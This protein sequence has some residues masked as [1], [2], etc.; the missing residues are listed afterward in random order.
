[1]RSSELPDD[2]D[3]EPCENAAVTPSLIGRD[4]QLG[5]LEGVIERG[6]HVGA[7]A[8]VVGPAGIGKTTLVRAA[9]TSSGCR[10][11][12]GTCL[13]GGGA[14]GY[15][16]WTQAL[17]GVA[18]AFGVGLARELAGDDRRLL[19]NIVTVAA[20]ADEPVSEGTSALLLWDAVCTWLHALAIQAPLLIVLDDLHWADDSS[21]ALLDFIASNGVTAGVGII[22]LYRP[23]ELTPRS[24]DRLNSVISHADHLELGGLDAAA[25]HVLIERVRGAP[26]AAEVTAEIHRRSAGHP[27]F[28]RELALL[29][30]ADVVG[31]TL[32]PAA[33]REAI[34]R[35]LRPLSRPTRNVL[36]GASLIG[37]RLSSDVVARA[38]EVDDDEVDAAI[39]E[40]IEAGVIVTADDGVPTFGHDL[41]RETLLAGIAA[42]RRA[43]MHRAV[44]GA[45]EDRHDR[46]IAT[47]PAEIAR[48]F[49]L[50]V[51]ADG[52]ERAI[53]WTLAAAAADSRALAFTDA[54]ALLR[55]L[56]TAVVAAG[57]TVSDD[58][59]IDILL[60]EA[61][62]LTRSGSPLDARG[63]LRV[64][65][66]LAQ[67]SADRSRLGRVALAST[68]LG[69]QFSARRDEL[70][71]DLEAALEHLGGANL[72]LEARLTATLAR[73]LQHS[74]AADR[75][76]AEPL[77]VRALHL[78][79]QGSDSDALMVCLLARHDVL[80]T[81]GTAD[82][83]AAIAEEI[84]V[85]ARRSRDAE[86]LAEGLLLLANAE[87]ERGSAAHL[88]ALDECFSIL[89]QLAQPRHRYT[90]ETRRAALAMLHGDLDDAERRIDTST[91]LGTRIREPDTGNVRMSQRLELVRA[92]GVAHEL[93]QFADEAMQHWTGAPVHANAVAAGFHARAGDI[94]RARLNAEAV[95]SLGTWQADRSYLWSVFIRELSWAA[96]ALADHQLCARLLADVAPLAH[97]CG[98]NGAVVAFAGS[99]AQT[100]SLLAVELGRTD[101]SDQFS[102]QARAAYQRLG[103]ITYLA[104]MDAHRIGTGTGITSLTPATVASFRRSGAVWHIEFAGAQASVA[105][106]KGVRD[107]AFLLARPGTD[108]HALALVGSPDRSTSSGDIVDRATLDSYRRR[109]A[110]IDDDATEA[111]RDNDGGRI[112]RIAMERD[113]LIT[114]LG[115]VTGPA[116]RARQF[117][118]HPGER[119]RKAVSARIRMSIAS[120]G[121]VLPALRDHLDRA[122]VTGTRCRYSAVDAPKWDVVP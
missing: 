85:L 110:D 101:D 48:H 97:T 109:L 94:E 80:W 4:V 35:R 20:G 30:I 91:A 1:M 43:L 76:R 45:L 70:T 21:L 55:R 66:D 12:W 54:S 86:R 34:E 79:R 74:V 93:Q 119:A 15:W 88:V 113:A 108:V 107:I 8:V 104:E 114:E 23:D 24:R 120:I 9:A 58:A 90:A 62:A 105:D 121:D 112:E 103:A 96:V 118:N 5:L 32:V 73:E 77:S 17:N 29:S 117:A 19:A 16:P 28:A 2:G 69:S 31:G 67:R 39:R 98:V 95:L 22:G 122:I 49:T 27:F 41:I 50:A 64:A 83:R 26:V 40:A 75:P 53:R 47:S 18:R 92:R 10:L 78:G 99:H 116:G 13:D 63:L 61:D 57:V 33:V 71:I 60:A 111:E 87:L 11:G 36:E 42:P 106:S 100:A 81:P 82:E 7:V 59:M 38:L 84:V 65:R 6:R 46:G 3:T 89:D 37:N 56:R 115:R 52:A 44:G 68:Q 72:A 14:P 102:R 25:V 51:A